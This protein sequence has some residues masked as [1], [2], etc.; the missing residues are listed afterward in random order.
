MATYNLYRNA[1]FYR[2]EEL[3]GRQLPDIRIRHMQAFRHDRI[4]ADC[5]ETFLLDPHTGNY[6]SHDY[7]S[8]PDWVK[9]QEM[10]AEEEAD[11]QRR[12]DRFRAMMG[13][14]R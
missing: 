12:F 5:I 4:S 9:R 8:L 10:E 1:V 6:I 2:V 3:H 14:G 13:S 7:P 11:R